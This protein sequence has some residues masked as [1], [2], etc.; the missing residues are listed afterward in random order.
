MKY[1]YLLLLLCN[2]TILHAQICDNADFE[3]GDTSGWKGF[4]G[5]IDRRGK[6][7]INDPG[8]VE[9]RHTITRGFDMDEV[10]A[11]CGIDIPKVEGSGA[12]SF[13]LGNNQ[14]GAQAESI[15][16]TFVVEPG[17]EFF[18]YK[19]AVILEDPRHRPFEQPRFEVRIFDEDGNLAPCGE[20]K[21][22][23]GPNATNE[24]F[25]ECQS[26]IDNGFGFAYNRTYWVKDWTV[27]GAD[28]SDFVGKK[29]TIEF[30]TT[31]CS[32]G[33]HAG[34]AY[35]EA[36]CRNLEIAVDGFCADS[37]SVT[38]SVTEGWKEYR[39]SNGATTN[40]TT[41]TG[42]QLGDTVSVEL[43]SFSGCSTTITQVIGP[44]PETMLY[45]VEDTYVCEGERSVL[46]ASG[47]N[48][49]YFLWHPTEQRGQEIVI[50]ES[51]TTTF[52]VEAFDM[53]G[54]P[55]GLMD[56]VNV[57]V[58]G[59]GADIVKNDVTCSGLPD[60]SASVNITGVIAP[61][62][63]LWSNGDTTA[64]IDSL[65]AGDYELFLLDDDG[66]GCS[67]TLGFTIEQPESNITL[68]TDARPAFCGQPNGRAW[69]EVENGIPPYTYLWEYDGST[70]NSLDNV[71]SG[72]YMV[73][74]TEDSGNGCRY[75]LEI[76]VPEG[77]FS[78]ILEGKD[79]ACSYMDGSAEVTV[80]GGSGS[81]DLLWSNGI[82]GNRIE[83]LTAGNY[84]VTVSDTNGCVITDSVEILPPPP[85][86]TAM[87]N[88]KD[89]ICTPDDGLITAEPMDGIPPY[90]YL[91]SDGQVTQ[92]ASGLSEGLYSVEV[93]DANGCQFTTSATLG[94][95]PP[96]LLAQVEVTPPRCAT[97]DG[98]AEVTL[99]NGL[100]PFTYSWNVDSTDLDR[101]DSLSVGFYEVTVTDA[102]GC[103]ATASDSITELPIL[104]EAEFTTEK[105]SYDLRN[106]SALIEVVSGTGPFTFEWMPGGHTG[107][108][109]DR[110]SDGDYTVT[111]TDGKGCETPIS[112]TIEEK[113][114]IIVPNAFTPNG[115]GINDDWQI[116]HIEL[117]PSS[118]VSVFNRWGKLLFES[119]GYS[120]TWKGI[121]RSDY[122]PA[123]TYYYS[124][125]LGIG[126]KKPFT[127]FVDIIK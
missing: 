96:P 124:I 61:F 70:T 37:D 97:N 99:Q 109:V 106:G 81:Y 29:V 35:V 48:V 123:D 75:T 23:A 50:E 114:R 73:T 89:P 105:E 33:G 51:D 45:P 43:T 44:S 56:T 39:W 25:R 85:P 41:V 49:G 40:S 115:D 126:L 32:Q 67:K 1:L 7:T 3:N 38:L 121:D 111:I 53:N 69:V 12:F 60:G 31:D 20:F 100:G 74:V 59:Y 21:V 108:A 127:G 82:T 72:N 24:G 102:N 19:Y 95:P 34:Y 52:V 122:F 107:S 2:M 91:W 13:R 6:V 83:D 16:K 68:D 71:P 94:P 26:R 9:G 118:K 42:L 11:G 64:T 93:L 101:V 113:E 47:E 63:Y 57:N 5:G 54:C 116:E 30:L 46:R 22:R 103:T 66:N 110:L 117:Y 62:K 55:T 86:V 79:N 28:L 88:T 27:S 90:T 104:T 8:M 78:T 84:Y 14:V 36:S 15:R 76:V 119:E 18:L 87:L 120:E 58:R 112:V 125:D 10:A 17:Q 92:T 4:T 80:L 65:I 77:Q 98:S